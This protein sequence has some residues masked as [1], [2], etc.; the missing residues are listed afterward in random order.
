ENAANAVYTILNGPA[1][2]GL[3]KSRRRVRVCRRLQNG[4][5]SPPRNPHPMNPLRLFPRLLHWLNCF[6]YRPADHSSANA[7]RTD[8]IDWLH[9][10]PFASLH[11]GCLLVIWAGWSWTA[12]AVAV[13]MY[14]V[15]FFAITAWYHRYFSHRTFRTWRVVQFFWAVVGCC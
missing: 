3:K 8:R 9:A 12:V 1:I 4:G 5:R 6:F 11:V 14:V 13:L 15:R 7:A 10:A 2:P